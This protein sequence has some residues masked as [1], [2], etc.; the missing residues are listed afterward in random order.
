MKFISKQMME[1]IAGLVAGLYFLF[2]VFVPVFPKNEWIYYAV[3]IIVIIWFII[4][5]RINRKSGEKPNQR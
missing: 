2:V 1:R 4:Y 5:G 3:M